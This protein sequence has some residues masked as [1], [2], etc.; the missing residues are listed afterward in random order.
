MSVPVIVYHIQLD[1][2]WLVI[3]ESDNIKKLQSIHQSSLKLLP[4]F[5]ETEKFR[6]NFQVYK[7]TLKKDLA[8][9]N[10]HYQEVA[11]KGKYIKWVSNV[12]FLLLTLLVTKNTKKNPFSDCYTHLVRIYFLLYIQTSHHYNNIELEIIVAHL[13]QQ[14]RSKKYIDTN[15]KNVP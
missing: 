5:Q 10:F 12:T 3:T 2:W 11:L 9:K 4:H 1:A 8:K 15:V 14:I 13:R 6:L 7:L